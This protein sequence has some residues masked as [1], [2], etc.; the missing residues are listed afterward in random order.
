MFDTE[1]MVF[2]STLIRHHTHRQTNAG[3]TRTNKLTNTCKNIMLSVIMCT[4]QL[5]VLL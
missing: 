3:H 1:D 4:Q 2:A 5:L